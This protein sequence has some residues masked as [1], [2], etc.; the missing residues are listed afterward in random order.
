LNNETKDMA[1]FIAEILPAK[2]L[3]ME[4]LTGYAMRADTMFAALF[5]RQ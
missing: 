5:E 3:R 1:A 4:T 2:L